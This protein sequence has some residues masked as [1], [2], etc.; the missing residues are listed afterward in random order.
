MGIEILPA[1]SDRF[2]DVR[3]VL[4]PKGTNKTCWCLSFRLTATEHLATADDERPEIMRELTERD[5]APGLL[6]YVDG[7]VAGWTGF[8]PREQMGR[9]ARSKTIQWIDDVPVW[10]LV[11]FVVKPQ[12]RGQGVARELLSSAVDYARS[13]GAPALEGYPVDPEGGR[14]SP[15]NAFVGTTRLFEDA[16]FTRAAQTTSKTGGLVRWIVRRDL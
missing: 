5:I 7:E 1:T 6:A 10:S 3:L 2:D 11:C 12:F 8:A 15:T 9:L 14:L 4:A 13:H 16:G